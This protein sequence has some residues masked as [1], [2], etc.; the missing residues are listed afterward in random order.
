MRVLL[1][2]PPQQAWYGPHL[3]LPSLTAFLRRAGLEVRQ[4]DLNQELNRRLLAPRW[5]ARA[6]AR[7]RERA[8]RGGPLPAT[9][10]PALGWAEAAQE[11]VVEALPGALAV[12]RDPARLAD[13]AALAQAFGTLG[14]AYALF[15][16]GWH[17]T[18]VGSSLQLP[19]NPC[20]AAEVLAA[21][22]DERHNPYRELY[23]EEVLPELLADPWQPDLI[24]L[25]LTY[26]EQLV[27]G[28]TLAKLLGEALPETPLVLGGALLSRLLP[29]FRRAGRFPAAFAPAAHVVVHEGETALL[30][31]CEALDSR[32]PPGPE[33]P[34]LL[35]P[36]PG[37]G[38]QLGP[39]LQED[40][41]T[42]PTPDFG[43][44]VLRDY[45]LAEPIL[46]LLT[47]RGC[48]W[49]RCGFCT[50]H[51]G[52][53]EQG[54]YRARPVAQVA[55]DLATLR[56]RDGA[57]VVYLVDEAV[58]LRN[59][60][61]VARA[62][63]EGGLGLGWFGDVRLERGLTRALLDE[64]RAGGC[65]MLI[66]G[67]ESGSQASLDRMGKGIT[68][69]QARRILRDATAAG[70]FTVGMFF[71]G[72]PGETLLDAERTRR[73]LEEERAHLG[74]WG[75]GAFSLLE[76]SPAFRR[77]ADH[78]ITWIGAEPADGELGNRYA[79]RLR[80]GIDEGSAGRIAE[81]IRRRL[82]AE[83]AP[84]SLFP[85]ELHA[86]RRTFAA[87]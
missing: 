18:A 55:D 20:C 19:A 87:G 79:Y 35:S 40:V 54:G 38:L 73:F 41:A 16:I 51:G 5:L 17:P 46:P 60:R 81:A 14:E 25:G 24:G 32:R 77:P 82:G 11:R 31:L 1:L 12:L 76:G 75:L 44:L 63:R 22:A 74:A 36:L 7:A 43:G 66:F 42:L 37:G 4:R 69:D 72:F 61:A 30:R 59:L 78:G 53:G 80:Q 64:L 9:F 45:L 57:R 50:H 29:A 67:Q 34:N 23:R 28:L 62:N 8:R 27:P 2:Y 85:R 13:D 65:Q 48:Y 68:V 58:P 83:E 33:L 3:G 49:G 71:I 86:L 26:E 52:Y 6:L 47:S 21:V 39:A 10:A 84:A 56:R 70:I 15:S